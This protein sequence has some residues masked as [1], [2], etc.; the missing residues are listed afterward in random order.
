MR[1]YHFGKFIQ[2]QRE[3]NHLSQ[4]Q[5]GMLVGVS[6]KAVSKWENGS[7]KPQCSILCKLSAVLGVTVD[8][9][10]AGQL[11]YFENEAEKKAFLQKNELWENVYQSLK[12]R[13]GDTLPIQVLSRYLSE[14]EELKYT[15]WITYFDLFRQV[16]ARS[17]EM[18]GIIRIQGSI[19]AS[20]V[21][22][23][24]GATETNPL[25]PHYYCSRCRKLEFVPNI[26]DGWDLPPKRCTCGENLR[27]DGHN[28]PFETLLPFLH[29]KN[30]FALSL[31]PGM[32][33]AFRDTIHT[34]YTD[35]TVIVLGKREHPDQ[36]TLFILDRQMSNITSGQELPYEEYY[37]RFKKYPAIMLY[38]SEELHVLSLMEKNTH[39]PLRNVPFTETEILEAFKANNTHGIPEFKTDF[40]KA[41]IKDASP[42]SFHD[43]IQILGLAHGTGTWTGNAQLLVRQGMPLA[44]S[45][46]Y[47]DD[48]FH[49]IR[50]KL[51]EKGI[52]DTGLALRI[53]EDVNH[54]LPAQAGVFAEVK[55]YS[56]VLGIDNWFTDSVEKIQYIFPKAQGIQ[57]VK[58]MSILMW[59]KIHFPAIYQTYC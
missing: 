30:R 37:N 19:G 40:V 14:Y 48:I 28:L 18:G 46:A 17:R 2:E 29:K 47:R 3:R 10:L 13:Y 5:L 57:A 59:Y 26:S 1:D 41:M 55:K 53:M 4:F 8:E 16:H 38:L 32:Y 42:Q 35:K 56:T 12:D 20:F 9:L 49:Y 36:K 23:V 58:D 22:F 31:S 43:L 52:F 15:D 33:E 39:I 44:R 6:D 11:D 54:Y 21:A 24:M 51:T 27:G 34:W 50:N 25:P 45:I 7:S